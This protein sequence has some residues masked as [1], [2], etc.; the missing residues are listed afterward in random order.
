MKTRKPVLLL[1]VM[2]L[3]STAFAQVQISLNADASPNPRISDWIDRNEMVVLTVTNT[4]PSLEGT[5]YKIRF[6]LYRD[7]VLVADNNLA[8]MPEH[9]LIT[10]SEVFMADEVLP[11]NAVNF[12]GSVRELVVRTGLLPAGTYRICISLVDLQMK[13][14]SVPEEVCRPMIITGYQLPEL[15]WPSGGTTLQDVQLTG[16]S[17]TWSPMIPSPSATTGLKYQVV[18]TEVY[19][20]QSPSQALLVNYPLVDVEVNGGN[21]LLWP[22]DAD[23]PADTTR[24]VWSV[25]PLTLD[26]Q[27]Y[28]A[29]NGGFAVPAAFHVV[30]QGN[31]GVSGQAV[32]GKEIRYRFILAYSGNDIPAASVQS[33]GDALTKSFGDKKIVAGKSNTLTSRPASSGAWSAAPDEESG[34]IAESVFRLVEAGG[35]IEAGPGIVVIGA[36]QSPC[37]PNPCGCK[38]DNSVTFYC[39]CNMVRGWCMCMFCPDFAT[40][41]EMV[42]EDPVLTFGRASNPPV[43]N[44]SVEVK[45]VIV[46]LMSPEQKSREDVLPGILKSIE[47]ISADRAGRKSSVSATP[48]RY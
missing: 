24:F 14:L 26:G 3:G 21:S 46:M 16:T 13:T 36:K 35:G 42:V 20:H 8:S 22:Y 17:F 30:P 9:Q 41:T 44:D 31:A 39:N 38:Q 12:Y 1:F 6:S 33:L 19:P 37:P 40:L 29:E 25:R 45:D 18:V 15:V 23:I 11:M 5:R 47:A 4:T 32:A 43:T 34:Q 28:F 10:G 7:D 2:L 48:V 27:P